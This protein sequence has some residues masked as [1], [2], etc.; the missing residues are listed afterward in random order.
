MIGYRASPGRQRAVQFLMI[1]AVVAAAGLVCAAVVG[2]VTG[3]ILRDEAS[4]VS[5]TAAA[6]GG[7]FLGYPLGVIG[8]LVMLRRILQLHGSLLLGLIGVVLA[9]AL[10]M[11]AAGLFDLS[12][13][14]SLVYL[15]Y[16]AIVPLLCVFGFLLRGVADGGSAGGR[17]AAVK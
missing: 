8:G 13:N 4:G 16:F 14:A 7:A 10:T 11:F 1:A 2:V 12:A 15:I 9:S 3:F 5:W 6:V 17:D